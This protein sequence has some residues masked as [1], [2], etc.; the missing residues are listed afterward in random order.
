MREF[1]F[2]GYQDNWKITKSNGKYFLENYF[3]LEIEG[4]D[5]DEMRVGFVQIPLQGAIGHYFSIDDEYD[6]GPI[7]KEVQNDIEN[8]EVFKY[9]TSFLDRWKKIVQSE[10]KYRYE[11]L[12]S[13]TDK[14]FGKKYHFSFVVEGL[15][16]EFYVVF[17]DRGII[18][19][20]RGKRHGLDHEFD[21]IE[22]FD[23]EKLIHHFYHVSKDRIKLMF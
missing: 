3:D 23:H 12:R 1:T 4:L 19:L 2:H 18:S 20:T 13:V 11:D 14:G 17:Q 9:A 5:Q 15:A 16:E 21:V 6:Y 7:I 8:M 22:L 10:M